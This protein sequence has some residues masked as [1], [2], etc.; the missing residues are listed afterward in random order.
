MAKGKKRDYFDSFQKLSEIAVEESD[1]VIEAFRNFDDSD[2]LTQAISRC[3]ALEHEGD[4]INH[5]IFKSIA[6]DFMPPIDREDIIALAHSL[7]DVLDFIED[8]LQHTYMYGIT[9][10]PEDAL[11]F[12]HLIKKSCR[13]LDK[14]MEDFR[15]FKKSKKFMQLIVDINTYEEEGDAL[16]VAVM[17]RLHTVDN[18]DVLHVLVWSRMYSQMEKCCDAC[19]HTADVMNTI[20]LKNM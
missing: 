8:I 17:R 14:A 12:V 20:V 13:A 16:Y 1:L 11:K 15:N 9:A 5:D 3:H 10:I 7:D 18:S 19:E 2:S 6:V 4:S